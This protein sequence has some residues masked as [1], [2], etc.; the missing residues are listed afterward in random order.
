MKNYLIW[1]TKKEKITTTAKGTVEECPISVKIANKCFINV[2]TCITN[3]SAKTG[4]YSTRY[5]CNI[6]GVKFGDS[7]KKCIE[8]TKNHF[9]ILD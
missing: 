3:I 6:T 9:N 8:H 4:R 1:H 7:H 5:I 2:F